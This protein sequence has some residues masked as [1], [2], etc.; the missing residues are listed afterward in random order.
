M[1]YCRRTHRSLSNADITS[2]PQPVLNLKAL[3][4][5]LKQKKKQAPSA[6]TVSSKPLPS[7]IEQGATLPRRV[8]FSSPSCRKTL[9]K[10]TLSISSAVLHPSEDSKK[11]LYLKMQPKVLFLKRFARPKTEMVDYSAR[12]SLPYAVQSPAISEYQRQRPYTAAPEMRDSI[13]R[14]RTIHV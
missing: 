10:Q 11:N 9:P 6:I 1:S 13:N 12:S 5:R 14:L 2:H 7:S 8:S 3:H 4:R